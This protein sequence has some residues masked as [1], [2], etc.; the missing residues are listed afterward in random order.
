M[1]EYIQCEK[2]WML[3]EGKC[4]KYDPACPEG[5]AKGDSGV[6]ECPTLYKMVNL[7]C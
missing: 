2:G 6:C 7:Q 3:I 5:T 1:C 4:V